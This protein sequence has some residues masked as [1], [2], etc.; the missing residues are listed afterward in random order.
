[1][2]VSLGYNNCE[3]DITHKTCEVCGDCPACTEMQIDE[4][5]S[6]SDVME[7]FDGCAN[8]IEENEFVKKLRAA[9]K[10]KILKKEK[11]VTHFENM[12]AVQLYHVL[13]NYIDYEN[14]QAGTPVVQDKNSENV[15]RKYLLNKIMNNKE[16]VASLYYVDNPDFIEGVD[17]A[18]TSELL[19]ATLLLINSIN[20]QKSDLL[21]GISE[22][23]YENVILTV[24]GFNKF[25]ID[26]SE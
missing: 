1:M 26:V 24:D 22:F 23:C 17:G 18:H 4:M 14:G 10:S 15:L 7:I 2:T 25:Y 6:A 21:V 13:I 20:D 16:K 3:N 11:M 5:F 19:D 12:P 9:F 8:K